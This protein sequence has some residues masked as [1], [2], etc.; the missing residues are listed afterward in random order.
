MPRV[1]LLLILLLVT[2]ASADTVRLRTGGT[3]EGIARD[4]GETI[5]VETQYGTM[6]VGKELVSSVEWKRTP[7]T[8]H[9]ERASLLPGTD[10]EGWLALGRWADGQGLEALAKEDY[11]RVIEIDPENPSAR[12]ALGHEKV[13]GRWMTRDEAMAARGHVRFEGV[14]M[15]PEAAAAAKA[16][17]EQQEAERRVVEEQWRVE[18]ERAE[19]DAAIARMERER[20]AEEERQE[21]PD[22]TPQT[23]W[24]ILI[25]G[26]PAPG[27]GMQRGVASYQPGF[28]P[29]Y[30]TEYNYRG[31]TF[32][33]PHHL[34]KPP[35]RGSQ[36]PG[37][38][39]PG[40]APAPEAGQPSEPTPP[41]PAEPP[42][43][44][45]VEQPPL[46]QPPVEQAP[47]EQ[48]PIDPQPAPETPPPQE[49]PPQGDPGPEQP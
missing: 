1:T 41:P 12:A 23:G 44:P 35:A 4:T 49:E 13:G 47:V 26:G 37:S 9:K 30:R 10:W 16:Q 36:V 29:F 42:P 14:W 6:E 46:E 45:P 32:W 31:S 3:I 34:S 24:T 8:E 48:P 22:E 5:V 33:K 28:R 15:T 25:Y 38:T 19:L 40:Q 7:I 17:R 18:R 39:L 20:K 2:A 43:A 11:E 21:K 27:Q